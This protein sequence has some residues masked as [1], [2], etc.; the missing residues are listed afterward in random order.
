VVSN[1][2]TL[3]FRQVTVD[4]AT[5]EFAYIETGLEATDQLVL[6]AIS[7]PLAGTKVRVAGAV[8]EAE[9]PATQLADAAEKIEGQ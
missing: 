8:T 1:D 3:Q 9:Q 4:R 5:A 7:N 2:N 6:S